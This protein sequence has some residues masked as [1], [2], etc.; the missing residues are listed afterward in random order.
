M[1]EVSPV[2]FSLTN[3]AAVLE[4]F[5]VRVRSHPVVVITS[6]YV[7]TT[8]PPAVQARLLMYTAPPVV[9]FATPDVTVKAKPDVKPVALT[10]TT[11]VEVV[12]ELAT[13]DRM[14]PVVTNVPLDVSVSK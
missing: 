2:P 4:L 1:P 12:A 10:L 9:R 14:S 11:P 5:H 6:C 7:T 3:P 8:A 13:T